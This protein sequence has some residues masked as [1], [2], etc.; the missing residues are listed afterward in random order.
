[1]RCYWTFFELWEQRTINGR[2][3]PFSCIFKYISCRSQCFFSILIKSL[4]IK[5]KLSCVFI[6]CISKTPSHT[7]IVRLQLFYPLLIKSELKIPLLNTVPKLTRISNVKKHPLRHIQTVESEK[8]IHIGN[9]FWHLTTL[10]Q[11]PFRLITINK[12]IE[13]LW[14]F[15]SLCDISSLANRICSLNKLSLYI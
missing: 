4:Y 2:P 6:A 1:M 5:L 13:K 11:K 8:N 15:N 9:G 3:K 7:L 12:L 14:T 10:L